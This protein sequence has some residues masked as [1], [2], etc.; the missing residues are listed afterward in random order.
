MTASMV[1]GLEFELP[2]LESGGKL[3]LPSTNGENWKSNVTLK[4]ESPLMQLNPKFLQV[5]RSMIMVF[6]FG[7][8]LYLTID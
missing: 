4:F 6:R 7:S 1:Q 5:F 8:T 3:L 2:M